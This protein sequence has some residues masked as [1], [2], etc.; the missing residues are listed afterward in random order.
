MTR[1]TLI[2]AVV[3]AA[4][5]VGGTAALIENRHGAD[6]S[7]AGSSSELREFLI[8]R[9]TALSLLVERGAGSATSRIDDPVRA[10]LIQPV[11][12][13]GAVI[14]PDHTEVSGTVIDAERSARV[15]G[16][17]HLAVR[18]DSLRMPGDGETY[19]IH[20]TPVS[21][22]AQGTKGKD[23]LKIGIPA[24]AGAILG[25]VLGGGK[26]AVIGGAAGGGAGTAYVMS[27]RGPE[28]ALPRGAEVSVRLLDD[29]RV[30]RKLEV[31]NEKAEEH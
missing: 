25:G 1:T 20:T 8:P 9:G 18:F 3:L 10:R 11:V 12:I 15:K 19:P 17:A 24:A 26:G 29:V 5:A 21:R 30:H 6:G 16:R 13:D 7:A 28:V 31:R 4:C 23:A 14:V 22:T 2:W 27:H